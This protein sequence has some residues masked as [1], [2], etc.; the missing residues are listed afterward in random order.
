MTERADQLHHDKAPAHSTALVQAF[1]LAK[2]HITQV[3]QIPVQPRFGSLQLLAFPEAKIA[4]EREEFC[5]CGGH[6]VHKFS[7]WCFAADWLDPLEGDCSWMHSKVSSDWLPSYIK[8]TWPVLE[9]FKIPGSPRI[10]K[11]P[12]GHITCQNYVSV[13]AFNNKVSQNGLALQW[14]FILPFCAY[15]IRIST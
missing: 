10:Q 7:Q 14:Q 8:A 2:H 4:V 1:F 15:W 13:L 6:T 3:Y 12:C 9:I 11:Q 5:E